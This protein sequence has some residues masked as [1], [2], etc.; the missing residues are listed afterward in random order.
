MPVAMFQ[1]RVGVADQERH[2]YATMRDVEA[3][4]DGAVKRSPVH[5]VWLDQ[6]PLVGPCSGGTRSVHSSN[7]AYPILADWHRSAWIN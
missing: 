4:T 3:R 1:L 2:G 7:I 5:A 6:T